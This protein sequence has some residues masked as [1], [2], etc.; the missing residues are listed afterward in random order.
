[1]TIVGILFMVLSELEMAL[2]FGYPYLDY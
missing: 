2:R 1:M